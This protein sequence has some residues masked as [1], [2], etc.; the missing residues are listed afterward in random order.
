MRTVNIKISLCIYAAQCRKIRINN[1]PFDNLK[2]KKKRKK[3][4]EKKKKKKKKKKKPSEEMAIPATNPP[5]LN[6]VYFN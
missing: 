5:F 1:F 2:K 6:L 3:K 4:K